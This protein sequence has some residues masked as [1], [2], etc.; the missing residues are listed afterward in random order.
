MNYN[1]AT[2]WTVRTCMDH[3]NDWP[4]PKG[5]VSME[6]VTCSG[7]DTETKENKVS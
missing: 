7:G 6:K 4:C 1:V 5:A 3:T 2:D